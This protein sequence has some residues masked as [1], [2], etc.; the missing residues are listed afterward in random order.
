MSVSDNLIN[1]V[2][3]KDIQ[4]IR[5]CLAA[6]IVFDPNLTRG[7]SE[8]LK[9]CLE[10]GI[11]EDELYERHDGRSLDRPATKE[12]FSDLCAELGT[13]FSRERVDAI[14]NVGRK[15]HPPKQG[16]DNE[17]RHGR[18]RMEKRKAENMALP[19]AVFA[20]GGAIVGG[21]V[22]G[23]LL[24]KALIGAVIGVVGGAAV[25]VAS[26]KKR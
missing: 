22:G 1:A 5:D 21:I 24:K 2:S 4:S 8:S 11:T 9:Y 16:L 13:N 20:I 10:N 15:L 3:E 12:A 6:S 17:E 19:M 18:G 14:R 7:F 25:A 26:G 23:L